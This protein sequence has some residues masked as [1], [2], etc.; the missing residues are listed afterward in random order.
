LAK[1]DEIKK[2]N[3]ICPSKG[4]K[5]G[6]SPRRGGDKGGKSGYRKIIEKRCDSLD[7]RCQMSEI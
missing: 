4:E 1:S 3:K 5:R 7:V 6:A 2:K